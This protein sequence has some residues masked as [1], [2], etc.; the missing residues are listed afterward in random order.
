MNDFVSDESGSSTNY[1]KIYKNFPSL[2]DR[3]Q[4]GILDKLENTQKPENASTSR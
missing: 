2:V 1:A 3:L 4:S